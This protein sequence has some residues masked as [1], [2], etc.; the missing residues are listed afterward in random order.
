RPGGR[1]TSGGSSACA[2]PATDG[3]ES[4]AKSVSSA[5]RGSRAIGCLVRPVAGGG[6]ETGHLGEVGRRVP[7]PKRGEN[8]DSSNRSAFSER[9]GERRRAVGDVLTG[10][11]MDALLRTQVPSVLDVDPSGRAVDVDVI[12]IGGGVNGTGVA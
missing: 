2:F 6:Q 8:A 11:G 7:P 9:G 4:S 1:P 10:D 5:R 3:T 12:V